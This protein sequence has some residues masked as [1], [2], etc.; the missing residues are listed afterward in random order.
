MYIS[1]GTIASQVWD[2]GVPGATWDG[3]FWD[4]ILPGGTSIIFEVRASDTLFAKDTPDATLP[5]TSVG[6]IFPVTSGLP[7]GRYMQWRATLTTPDTSETPVLE[8]VRVYHY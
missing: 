5:W 7:S 4:E 1:P 2:T 6:G 3:L 8:E